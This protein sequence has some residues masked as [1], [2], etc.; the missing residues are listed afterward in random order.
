[1]NTFHSFWNPGIMLLPSVSIAHFLSAPV[2]LSCCPTLRHTPLRAD[3]RPA[4]L[5]LP[6]SR[7]PVWSVMSSLLLSLKVAQQSLLSCRF[8]PIIDHSNGQTFNHFF[9]PSIIL[10]FFSNLCI[11][12]TIDTIDSH[13]Q[14]RNRLVIKHYINSL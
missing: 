4:C 6:Q 9:P 11:F 12:I 5:P 3:G 7:G 14:F 13:G 1:M 2:C 10:S 8:R